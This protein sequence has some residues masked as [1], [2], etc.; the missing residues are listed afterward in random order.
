MKASFRQASHTVRAGIAFI[1]GVLGPVQ[2]GPQRRTRFMR[3][4]VLS[5]I[6]FLSSYR[7]VPQVVRY[8]RIVNGHVGEDVFFSWIRVP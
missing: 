1:A 2:R 6:V 5:E 8:D 4:A 3:R 7:G